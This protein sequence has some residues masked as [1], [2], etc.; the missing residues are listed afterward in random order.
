M[1]TQYIQS[2]FI[3][4]RCLGCGIPLKMPTSKRCQ[5]CNRLHQNALRRALPAPPIPQEKACKDCGVVFLLSEFRH[6]PEN[7][8]GRG[9]RCRGCEGVKCREWNERRPSYKSEWRKLHREQTLAVQRR[10]REAHRD[11]IREL[12]RARYDPERERERRKRQKEQRPDHYRKMS[13]E[14][15]R[16]RHY[17]KK[18]GGTLTVKGWLEIREKLGNRCLCCGTTENITVDHIVP[19]SQG[20]RHDADNVQPL[21]LRCNMAKGTKTI[22]YRPKSD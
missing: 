12:E 22:D 1:Q 10:F 21:C 3:P 13:R 14:A 2:S 16:R 17:R 7:R 19:L 15:V 5:S 9:N 4:R 8:D 11:H 20:G 18:A 6:R